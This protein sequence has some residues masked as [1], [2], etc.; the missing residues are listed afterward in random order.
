MVFCFI[1][2]SK[3]EPRT[4]PCA[5]S[6]KRISFFSH[7]VVSRVEHRRA[8]RALSLAPIGN[9]ELFLPKYMAAKPLTG[10]RKCWCVL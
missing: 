6:E 10:L 8:S 5:F 7:W 9:L 3:A 1:V 4:A 2:Y